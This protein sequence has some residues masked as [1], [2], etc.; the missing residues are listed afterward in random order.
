MSTSVI[1]VPLWEDVSSH[2][3]KYSQDTSDITIRAYKYGN[4]IFGS[5]YVPSSA[6][7][8][9]AEGKLLLYVDAGYDPSDISQYFTYARGGGQAGSLKFIDI[10]YGCH[11]QIYT[12]NSGQSGSLYASFIYRL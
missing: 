8:S 5:L 11:L 9:L 12:M 4:M 10:G 7:S 1:Q 3:H 2:F 6:A